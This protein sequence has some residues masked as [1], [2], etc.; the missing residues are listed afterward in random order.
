MP[1][2]RGG[3]GGKVTGKRTDGRTL[4]LDNFPSDPPSPL[5]ILWREAAFLFNISN[6][7]PVFLRPTKPL[8]GGLLCALSHA[9]KSVEEPSPPGVRTNRTAILPPERRK[10]EGASKRLLLCPKF[11]ERFFFTAAPGRKY[12]PALFLTPYAIA[13]V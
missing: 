11:V 4:L 6:L 13:C 9:K 2:G 1:E 8:L 7:W 3:E 12:A 5:F 10:A